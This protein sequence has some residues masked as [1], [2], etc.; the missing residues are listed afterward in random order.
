MRSTVLLLGLV[1][2][3]SLSGCVTV[4]DMYLADGSIG[5]KI[6]CDG[7]GR[8]IDTC[9]EKAAELCGAHGFETVT[10]EGLSTGRSIE[11]GSTDPNSGAFSTRNIL[12]RCNDQRPMP[13]Y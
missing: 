13:R 7:R 2:T 3:A 6:T 11:K 5:H 12:V 1:S 10:R 9:F 8:S 4:N